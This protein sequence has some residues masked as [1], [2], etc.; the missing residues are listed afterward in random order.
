MSQGRL[1]SAPILTFFCETS[2]VGGS[3]QLGRLASAQILTFFCETSE[4]GGSSQ[5]VWGGDNFPVAEGRRVRELAES[6]GT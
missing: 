1:A 3:S 2:R 4:V 5:W 6:L